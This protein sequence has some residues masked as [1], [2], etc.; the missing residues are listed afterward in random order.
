LDACGD[1]PPEAF[2]EPPLPS[3]VAADW[4]RASGLSLRI[5]RGFDAFEDG[6]SFVGSTGLALREGSVMQH[7]TRPFGIGFRSGCDP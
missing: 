7:L 1:F 3:G 6:G 5:S 4:L 2:R